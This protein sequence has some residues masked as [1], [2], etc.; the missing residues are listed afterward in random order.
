M[1]IYKIIIATLPCLLLGISA[2]AQSQQPQSPEHQEKQMLEYIDK[3]VK[4]L[5]DL[6]ELEYWQEFYVDSTLNHDLHAR[7]EEL[8]NMQ[9]AKVEN[10]DLYQA[11]SDKWMQQID[12]SYKRFFTEEQWAKYWKTGARRAQKERDKRAAKKSR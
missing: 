3:E 6:L 9:K 8:Q 10:S 5:S 12:N 1:K 7:M 11:I 4:R 2:K